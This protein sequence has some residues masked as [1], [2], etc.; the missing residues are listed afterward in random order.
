MISLLSPQGLPKI[1]CRFFH[2]IAANAVL[3][4]IRDHRSVLFRW[5]S[6]TRDDVGG[7]GHGADGGGGVGDG[8]GADEGGD[9]DG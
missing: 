1:Y 2:Q 7:C 9:G 6:Q 5:I 4:F 3:S 8:G